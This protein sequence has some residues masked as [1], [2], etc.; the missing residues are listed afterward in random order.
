MTPELAAAARSALARI[1]ASPGFTNSDRRR[2][3]LR[4]IVDRTLD[5]RADLLG[6]HAI[7]IGILGRDVDFDPQTD[8]IVRLEISRLRRDLDQYYGTGGYDDPIR[9][10]IP[11]GQYRPVFE[12][13]D[14]NGEASATTPAADQEPPRQ[15]RWGRRRLALI[16]APAIGLVI[17]MG[18]WLLDPF[19]EAMSGPSHQVRGPAVIVLPFEAGGAGDEDQ[20][21][22]S[23]LTQELINDLMRFPDLRLFSVSASFQQRADADP[24]ELRNQHDIAYVVKGRIRSNGTD[25]R[26]SA[27]LLDAATEQ[28]IWSE[29]YDKPLTPDN[30]LMLE[31]ELA[32]SIATTLAQPYGIV[33]DDLAK[34]LGSASML[35][36]AS[37]SCVLRTYAYRRSFQDE[38]YPKVRSCLETTVERE[39]GYAEAWAMLGWLKLDAARFGIVADGDRE[40]TLAAAKDSATKAVTIDP[41]NAMG[42]QALAAI[43][44]YMGHYEESERLQRQA[45]QLNPNNPDL[46]AQLGWRLAVRG[47]F[48]EGIPYLEQ[49]IARTVN[50]PGWY[51]HLIAVNDCMNGDYEAMLA[52]AERSSVDGSGLSQSLL[53]IAHGA[54]G[55]DEAARQALARMAE[56]A[57]ELA[58]DPAAVYRNHHATEAIINTLVAGLRHAGWNEPTG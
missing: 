3:L 49:A 53:A 10:S 7:A 9:I 32:D 5:G 17:A 4:Y 25:L 20:L 35:S 12:M 47:N 50:A 52:A 44:H 27:Q 23:G 39:P 24:L 57:P 48:R 22:A 46:M 8:P 28:V 33:T 55:H 54:L 58:R 31:R 37:Y 40:R 51:Y 15:S 18:I 45:L 16:A 29:A 41:N 11:K 1:L 43:N 56:L 38:L 36:M 30:L 2:G 26:V 42:L 21:L 34:R 19:G 13:K 14:E 6:A